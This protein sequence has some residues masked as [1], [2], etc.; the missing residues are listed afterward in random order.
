MNRIHIGID[1]SINST[2]LVIRAGNIAKF[3]IFKGNTHELLKNGEEKNPLTK[4]ERAA[5]EA[6]HVRYMLYDKYPTSK[7]Y[8]SEENEYRKTVSFINLVSIISD[9]IH[10][11]LSSYM[12]QVDSRPEITVAIEGISYGSASH[13]TAVF[14]L[15]G[16]NYMI[17]MTVF[18][19]CPNASIKICT[20]AHLKKYTTG[21]GNANKDLMINAFRT[22]C[23]EIDVPKID[24]IADAYFLSCVYDQNLN[25]ELG[26]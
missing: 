26:T 17:R 16:L 19:T 12:L 5:Q 3:Y 25:N 1:P 18:A 15:A 8:T 24:D 11:E 10:T 2:G 6:G 22:I 13:T 20:P 9:V 21:M 14:D 4:A 7:E 23:P